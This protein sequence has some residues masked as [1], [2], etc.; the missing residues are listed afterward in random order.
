MSIGGLG[1]GTGTDRQGTSGKHPLPEAGPVQASWRRCGCTQSSRSKSYRGP[2]G[3]GTEAGPS[4]GLSE[5]AEGGEDGWEERGGE[6]KP[7]EKGTKV[8]EGLGCKERYRS[9]YRE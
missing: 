8:R 2:W 9:R 3:Q 7:L 4:R 1:V 6:V 5:D